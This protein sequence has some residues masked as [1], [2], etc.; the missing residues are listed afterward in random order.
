MI[1]SRHELKH[2]LVSN[3][4]KW[5][6]LQGFQMCSTDKAM[7]SN[8]IRN[9]IISNDFRVLEADFWKLSHEN[10]TVWDMRCVEP[11]RETIH[12]HFLK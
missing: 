8:E 7:F 9:A 6:K 11:T 12:F 1:I 5:Y 4:M 2:V 10:S 3:P